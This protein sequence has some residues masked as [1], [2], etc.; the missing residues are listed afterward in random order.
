[1]NVKQSHNYFP[2]S[3][4]NAENLFIVEGLSAMGSI[5]QKRDPQNDGVYALKGKIKNC[6]IG[7]SKFFIKNQ[8]RVRF[9]DLN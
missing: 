6:L 5:L 4:N 9:E 3:R 2:A 8:I 7:L 1:V